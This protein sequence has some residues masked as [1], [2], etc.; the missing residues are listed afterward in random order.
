VLAGAVTAY[1]MVASWLTDLPDYESADAFEVAQATRIYAADGTLIARLYLENRTVVPMSRIATDL[2]EAV[3][4]VE[5][6]RFYTHDGIDIQGI[7]RA[8]VT[9]IMAGSA[10]EGA[11]TITQQYIRNTV[12]LDERTDISIAARKVR[13]AFLARELEKRKGK[14][15]ILELYLNAIYFGE[16]AY[17]AQAASRTYFAKNAADLTLAEAA[18][19]AGLPQQ[20]SRLSPYSNPEGALARRTQVLSAC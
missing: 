6:E 9:D 10:K 1:A 12:L 17:G 3:V 4:A 11:S 16:G 5:D 13:E 7:A 20:P 18:L 19:L 2:S 14:D 15:E 8:A